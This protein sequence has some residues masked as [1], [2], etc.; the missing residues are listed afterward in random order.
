MGSPVFQASYAEST[1]P[2]HQHPWE[3]STPPGSM[4]V[5]LC[6]DAAG[7]LAIA[8]SLVLIILMNFITKLINCKNLIMN[9]QRHSS[10]YAFRLEGILADV[11]SDWKGYWPMCFQIGGLLSFNSLGRTLLGLK[12]ELS[13]RAFQWCA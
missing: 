9:T 4:P 5:F 12:R 8:A 13:L 3:F 6:L 10:R 11:L 7:R 1:S 2:P